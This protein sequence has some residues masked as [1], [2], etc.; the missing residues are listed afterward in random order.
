MSG[1]VEERLPLLAVLDKCEVMFPSQGGQMQMQT[2]QQQQQ[3]QQAG[4]SC[5][6]GEEEEEGLRRFTCG[7][8]YDAEA[9]TL[10]PLTAAEV[11]ACTTRGSR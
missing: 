5:A 6:A 2:A 4:G 9:L 8:F 3:Q 7:I 1:H 11:A 10:R